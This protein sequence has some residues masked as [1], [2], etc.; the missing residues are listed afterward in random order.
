MPARDPSRVPYAGAWRF[1]PLAVALAWTTAAA[2]QPTAQPRVGVVL[3]GGSAKGFA[4]IG[5]LRVL[6]E[7]GVTVDV[8]A[9][10]SM[11]AL[12]GGLYAIGYDADALERVATG[13][14]WTRLF[15][16]GTGPQTVTPA[17]ALRAVPT[18]VEFPLEGGQLQLPSG[19]V[20]GQ[21]VWR[22]LASLTWPAILVRD[23][24]QLPIPFAAVATD[25]ETGEAVVF[26][27]GSLADALRASMSLPGVFRPM[28]IDGR[29][30][31]DGGIARNLPSAEARAL[32]ASLLICSDVSEPLSRAGELQS[33]VDVLLQTVSF[34][35]NASTL[36]QRQLCDVLITPD[37]E[38]LSGTAF[39]RAADWIARGER[40]ARDALP[41]LSAM[42]R[43]PAAT[44]AGRRAALL[45][46]DATIDVD[47]LELTGVGP[48]ARQFAQRAIELTIPGQITG[49]QLEHTLDQ[50]QASGAFDRVTYRLRDAGDRRV[51]ELRLAERSQ[52]AIGFGFRFDNRYK[53]SLL[54]DATFRNRWGFGTT[55]GVGLRLGEQA[56]L[57]VQHLREGAIGRM[58]LGAEAG[59]AETPLDIFVD[60]QRVARLRV[61]VAHAAALAG[62]P[63]GRR[64]VIAVRLKAERA[65]GGTSVAA[66]RASGSDVFASVAG[67]FW[68]SSLDRPVFPRRGVEL[69]VRS[70]AA[71]ASGAS[72]WHHLADS[73]VAVPLAERLSLTARTV[74][75]AAGGRDLPF[76]YRFFL[77]GASPSAVFTERQPMFPG[78]RGQE[79]SGRTVQLLEIG[80]QYE[81]ANQTFV[82]VHGHVGN[83]AEA[84]KLPLDDYVRGYEVSI[85]ALT[86]VGP[87]ELSLSGADASDRPRLEFR[88]GYQF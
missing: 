64:G 76:H 61:D 47:A 15:S 16:A 40:A 67:S 29:L 38:G 11:G 8:I 1:L 51:L 49:P 74:L 6:E 21:E 85:G 81:L 88:L 55:T 5:V 78:L 83:T 2:A 77:G 86:F 69:I 45:G 3:S 36:E 63:L 58:L 19:L 32:G 22:L 13:Q 28:P 50:L 87:V 42:S 70:E 73:R 82:S 18:L 57:Q 66:E 23:F 20:G 37:I 72:F 60:E 26:D 43:A 31:I 71:P 54:F 35:M 75:G 41:R 59:Y 4:H 62:L 46:T 33:F 53:A 84:W 7:A 30:L 80:G 52:D 68:W 24:R 14:D 39:D 27:S 34:Q 48:D 65:R 56:H 79:R 44:P 17:G 12:V 10:T 25:V 9:G